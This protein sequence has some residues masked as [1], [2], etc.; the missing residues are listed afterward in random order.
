MENLLGLN[1][2]VTYDIKAL[3][4]GS[5]VI[6]FRQA[7][8]MFDEAQSALQGLPTTA[9][10]LVALYTSDEMRD[11][12]LTTNGYEQCKKA[13]AAVAQ[14]K[15]HTIFVSPM[16]SALQTVYEVFKNHPLYKRINVV[17][18]PKLKEQ[19]CT[20]NDIPRNIEELVDQYN[21]YFYRFDTSALSD[22]ASPKQYFVHDLDAEI[23][24]VI[25]PQ[26]K[27]KSTDPTGTNAFDLL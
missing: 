26:I 17:L 20:C 23:R 9:D 24:D 6:L 2:E 12:T 10:E 25:E 19:T 7:T 3:N 16:R 11:T 4:K 21:D 18:M 22:Y 27:E 15:V 1:G 14:I 8:A 5:Q 13:E